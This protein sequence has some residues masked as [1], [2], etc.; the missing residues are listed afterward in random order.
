[1]SPPVIKP[2]VIKPLLPAF[3]LRDASGV[4]HSFPSG[5]PT[6]IAMVKE[7]CP[8]CGLVMPLVEAFH[9]SYG[10]SLDVLLV[11]QTRT[12]TRR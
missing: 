11:G 2:L 8:T 10:A 4:D 3:S 6:L 7:D 12:A 5:K 1:M 9:R